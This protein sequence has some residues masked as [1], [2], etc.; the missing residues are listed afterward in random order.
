FALAGWWGGEGAGKALFPAPLR[1]W[2]WVLRALGEEDVEV[3]ALT[4]DAVVGAEPRLGGHVEGE[5]VAVGLGPG[6]APG[7][8][9]Q[10]GGA[11]RRDARLA[12]VRREAVRTRDGQ[13]EG[14]AEG[15][16]RGCR[17][18]HGERAREG[19]GVGDDD[20]SSGSGPRGGQTGARHDHA[21]GRRGRGGRGVGGVAGHP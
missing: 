11:D 15:T 18:A 9:V 6:G 2:L 16:G 10:R 12:D 19:A 3:A 17:G 1:S 14:R 8:G 7:A 5:G 21:A 4:R 20:R 13:V